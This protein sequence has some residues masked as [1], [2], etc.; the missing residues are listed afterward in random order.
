MVK[1][2]GIDCLDDKIE[3]MYFNVQVRSADSNVQPGAVYLL[4]GDLN[5]LVGRAY[6]LAGD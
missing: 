2:G 3:H 4:K 6:R 5:F 1:G